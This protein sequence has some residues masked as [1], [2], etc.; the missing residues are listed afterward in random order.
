[1]R[2]PLQ[3]AVACDLPRSSLLA[4]ARRLA[5]GRGDRRGLR[6]GFVGAAGRPGSGGRRRRRLRMPG[7]GL[8]SAGDQRGRTRHR[9]GRTRLADSGGTRPP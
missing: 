9:F 6:G 3:I 5:P 7:P 4:D 8:R 1:M 2:G